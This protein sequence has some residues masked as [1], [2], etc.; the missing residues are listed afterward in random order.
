MPIVLGSASGGTEEGREFFQNR[1]GLFGGWVAVIAGAFL[2]TY[3]LLSNR[4]GEHIP[5]PALPI[6]DPNL[7][8]LIATCVA[9]SLWVVNARFGVTT[10][11]YWV[12][13]FPLRP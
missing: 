11:D 2:V 4:F 8:H 5:I 1:L 13:R 7:Y 10:T 6:G 12:T 3:A 9:G